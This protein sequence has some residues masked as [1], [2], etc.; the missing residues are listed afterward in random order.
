MGTPWLVAMTLGYL[1][2]GLLV[3]R[4]GVYLVAAGVGAVLLAARAAVGPLPV[5]P[6]VLGL[7][8]AAPTLVD[9]RRGGRELTQSGQ[10]RVAAER[11]G[12][13][14]VTVEP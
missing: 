9:A 1:A 10:P 8:H 3:V 4:G 2:T 11:G 5:L 7:L 13:T 14:S 6:V 12:S